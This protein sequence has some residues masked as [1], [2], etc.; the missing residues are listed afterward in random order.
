M[1]DTDCKKIQ[2]TKCVKRDQKLDVLYE[3]HVA[4]HAILIGKSETSEPKNKK[5][6]YYSDWLNSKDSN[7][8]SPDHFYLLPVFDNQ[9]SLMF[10]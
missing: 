10:K 9:L 5:W 7:S 1:F 4:V 2:N 6:L 8:E 3:K